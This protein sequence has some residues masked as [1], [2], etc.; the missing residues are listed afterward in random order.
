[1]KLQNEVHFKLFTFCAIQNIMKVCKVCNV[2]INK[3]NTTIIHL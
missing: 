2:A 3:T 1:M